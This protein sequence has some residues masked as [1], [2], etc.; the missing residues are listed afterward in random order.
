M[1]RPIKAGDIVRVGGTADAE[2]RR[3]NAGRFRT[4][5]VIHRAG[6]VIKS[7]WGNARVLE[8]LALLDGE[9]TFRFVNGSPVNST[10]FPL[11]GLVPLDPP[12]EDK[13]IETEMPTKVA[14]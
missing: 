7:A 14:A 11:S 8:D 5:L 2:L 3:W 9:M 10:L 1:T 4:V 12:G 6:S 13:A